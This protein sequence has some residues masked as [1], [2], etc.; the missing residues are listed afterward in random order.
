VFDEKY[1]RRN[2]ARSVMRK[3]ER[4]SDFGKVIELLEKDVPDARKG[5]GEE[6]FHAISRLTPMVNVELLIRDK[7]EGTLLTWRAD[8]LYGPGWHFPGGV[9]RFKETLAK[10]IE[11]VARLELGSTV[12]HA[13][14]PDQVRTSI[15]NVRDIRGHFVSLL[16]KCKL[17]SP[18]DGN[19]KGSTNDPINGQWAWHRQKPDNL[20]PVQDRQFGYL[21][22]D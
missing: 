6:L 11:A 5:L 1:R 12:S 7:E 2:N 18:L 9:L 19:C 21:F 14:H 4:M 16:F 13:E 20:L 15:S 3:F 8:K 22:E 17:T 10:R